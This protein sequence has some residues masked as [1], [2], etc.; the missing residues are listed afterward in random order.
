ML[1]CLLG[2]PREYNACCQHCA[3]AQLNDQL[4][5]PKSTLLQGSKTLAPHSPFPHPHPLHSYIINQ[6]LKKQLRETCSLGSP[7]LSPPA[8]VSFQLNDCPGLL[9]TQ[10]QT[11]AL[12]KE[13]DSISAYANCPKATCLLGSNSMMPVVLQLD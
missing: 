10:E 4:W 3:K 7:P 9:Y 5:Q 6:I 2:P 12:R 1:L 13:Q 11:P 8:W